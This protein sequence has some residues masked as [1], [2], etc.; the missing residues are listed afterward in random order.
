MRGSGV[1]IP[2]AAPSPGEALARFPKPTWACCHVLDLYRR[3]TIAVGKWPA[4]R[5]FRGQVRRRR[6]AAIAPV[7]PLP[8]GVPAGPD[9][10]LGPMSEKRLLVIDDEPGFGAFV[11]QVAEGE[12][13][14]VCV[15]KIG[16]AHV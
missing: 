12:D 4:L 10:P 5:L 14:A 16:R 6:R 7:A 8:A 3:F 2:P 11:Q 13:F 9:F 1:Q 15:T